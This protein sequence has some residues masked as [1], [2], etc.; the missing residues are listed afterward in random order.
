MYEIFQV[1]FSKIKIN[2][3]SQVHVNVQE[4]VKKTKYMKKIF[5]RSLLI[6]QSENQEQ[7]RDFAYNFLNNIVNQYSNLSNTCPVPPGNYSLS[8]YKL[9]SHK[10]PHV[11]KNKKMNM[12]IKADYCFGKKWSKKSNSCFINVVIRLRFVE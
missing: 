10:L 11:L 5:E 8:N 7:G 3:L 1:L 6:C 4:Y 9:N 12:T 2:L